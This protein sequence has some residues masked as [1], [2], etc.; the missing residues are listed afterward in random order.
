MEKAGGAIRPS[1]GSD[2]VVYLLNPSVAI[3]TRVVPVFQ[4]QKSEYGLARSR[5]ELIT[6]STMS[7][8]DERMVVEAP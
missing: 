1:A 7:L 3:K 4:K 8:V 5:R 6:V 2:F